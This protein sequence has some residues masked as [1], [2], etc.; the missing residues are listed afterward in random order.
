MTQ[1]NPDIDIL[2][3]VFDILTAPEGIFK[4]DISEIWNSVKELNSGSPK[5]FVQHI[6]PIE[7]N[8]G[9]Y[10]IELSGNLDGTPNSNM[11]N[12]KDL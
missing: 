10:K 3:P 8:E 2:N 1:T 11:Y 6:L 4:K 5:N 12:R 7:T 9:I